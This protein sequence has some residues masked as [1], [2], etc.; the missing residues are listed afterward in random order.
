M[1][2]PK[3]LEDAAII[4][5]IKT[6]Y[7]IKK[8]HNLIIL[9]A[10][11]LLF[12]FAILWLGGY[13]NVGNALV[14]TT[15]LMLSFSSLTLVAQ[16]IN[17]E[18]MSR[19]I[20]LYVTSPINP[21]SYGLGVAISSLIQSALST[22]LVVAVY[23]LLA[24]SPANLTV[25]GAA[26]FVAALLLTW[27]ICLV[28]GL[29]IV[30]LMRSWQAVNIVSSFL[31]F[32]YT[33]LSPVYYSPENL[34]TYLQAAL[35]AIPLTPPIVAMKHIL[36]GDLDIANMI[37]GLFYAILLTVITAKKARWREYV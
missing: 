6:K 3:V 4:A 19:T 30:M 21:L 15:A 12:N 2:L 33:F 22:L 31:P 37:I 36:S 18:R 28:N 5:I 17:S 27:Y 1:G 10:F 34:P 16:G 29:L 32:L 13:R 25:A 26:L 9:S 23:V 35:Y 20:A 8:P 14:G 11:P 7:L 24:R